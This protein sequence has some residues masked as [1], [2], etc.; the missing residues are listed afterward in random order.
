LT[1]QAGRAPGP[2]VDTLIIGAG[3][4]G[5]VAARRLVDAGLSVRVLDKGRSVGGRLATR[6]MS[7]A[8]VDHGAQF[9]T[10][11]GQSLA[12]QV[13]D[14]TSRGLVTV[15]CRGFEGEDGH[16]RYIGTTGMNSLAK[17]LATGVDVRVP[18]MAVA[19]RFDDLGHWEVTTDDGTI[20][21]SRS[22]VSTAP[23]P[24]SFS[25]VFE[26]VEGLPR[27]VFDADYDRTLGLLVVLD[28]PSA[29]APP[30]GMQQPS[31]GVAFVADNA[32]KG[33]SAVP[34]LTLHAD[35]DWSL[36]RWDADPSAIESELHRLAEPFIGGAG[37]VEAQVKRWRFATPR[38]PWS[39]R[40]WIDESTRLVLGGD[41]FAG[42]RFEGAWESGI[43]A[44]EAV[45]TLCRS[46]R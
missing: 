30:G 33:I 43:A 38:Q 21:R 28:G 46:H 29:V 19:T 40:C 2:E 7:G 10:V 44:A 31:S 11:R 9:F 4:S 3:L 41:A 15:W 35:P 45:V 34:A 27:A 8:V 22:L 25:L 32:L 26:S 12:D 37:I 5:L 23:V 13:D 39:E 17:D 1:S 16:P 42:P 24:Q 6:R 18:S 36:E 20:H 14:W